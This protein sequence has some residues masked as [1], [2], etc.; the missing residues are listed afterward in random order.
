MEAGT[1]ELLS[2]ALLEELYERW[3]QQDAPILRNLR[4][5]LSH[6]EMDALVAPL[7]LEL[8]RDARVWWGWHDGADAPSR[9]IQER[10]I[11][12]PSFSY[13]PLAE[14][15]ELAYESE[16]IAKDVARHGR[17]LTANA[18][19]W[20]EPT[21]LPITPESRGPIALDCGGPPGRPSPILRVDGSD[22]PPDNSDESLLRGP[23]FRTPKARSFAEM[24]GWFTDGFDAGA[25]R[26]DKTRGYWLYDDTR[27]PRRVARSGL[28]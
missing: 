21:W 18:Q 27:L 2:E 9:S 3:V 13:V 16:Q 1:P 8:S 28:A 25:Y 6:A 17:G 23:S 26:Y 14:A 10:S 5:G 7:G 20:W 22:L 4:P 19:F 12:R 15:V 24:I 11:G